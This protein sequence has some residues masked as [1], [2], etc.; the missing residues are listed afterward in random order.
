ME[1]KTPN[2]LHIAVT[3]HRFIPDTNELHRSI[4]QV[5]HDILVCHARK[6]FF[7]YSALAEGS[8]Q[9]VARIALE[10]PKIALHVPLPK[11][12]VDYLKDFASDVSREN[13]Q[14]LLTSAVKVIPLSHIS[15]ELNAY[16]ELGKYLIHQGDIM[17]ALW[18]GVYNDKTG[19]TSEV[20]RGA[21]K[22]KK[23]VYWLYCPNQAVGAD[24]SLEEQKQIGELEILYPQGI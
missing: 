2:S 19:G 15:T 5:L 11:P 13:F 17:I 23:P 12:E 24:N 8:D 9:L 16:N 21:L 1:S 18:N 6:A 3:G 7:L 10:F 14:T 22:A 4:R 20:I